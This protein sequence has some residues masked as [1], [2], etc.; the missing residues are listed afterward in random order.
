MRIILILLICSTLSAQPVEEKIKARVTFGETPG[1]VVG[2][3]ENGKT[4]YYSY[5]I[6]NLENKEPVT[7]IT[8]LKL[9]Q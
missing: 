3:Y 7:S 6:A 9:A 1:I 4:Q 2:I 8:L 5:G